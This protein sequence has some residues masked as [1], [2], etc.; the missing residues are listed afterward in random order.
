[1]MN[2]NNQEQ[3]KVFSS[4]AEISKNFRKKIVPPLIHFLV[5]VFCVVFI[6][7]YLM[8]SG[9]HILSSL[10]LLYTILI[11]PNKNGTLAIEISNAV[12]EFEDNLENFKKNGGE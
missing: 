1:M 6:N 7:Y 12:D 9:Y 4:E 10:I 5:R 8:T 2:G 11:M 3:K